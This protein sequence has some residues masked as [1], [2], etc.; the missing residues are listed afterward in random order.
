MSKNAPLL[1]EQFDDITAR[2]DYLLAKSFSMDQVNAI[3]AGNPYWLSYSV[4]EIDRRLGYFQENFKLDGEETR[5]LAVA[6]PK[7]I[8]WGGVP[9]QIRYRSQAIP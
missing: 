6:E 4:E 9:G 1:F 2:V 8:T 7:L 3:L 5:S